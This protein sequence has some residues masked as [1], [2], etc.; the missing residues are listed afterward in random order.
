M[1]TPTL[2]NGQ[3]QFLRR[4]AHDLKPMTQVGKHGVTASVI[5]SCDEQLRAHELLKVKFLGHPEDQRD[6][7]EELA[8]ATRAILVSAIGGTI[9]LYRPN[10]EPER[11]RIVLP[12]P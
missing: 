4:L 6:M 1:N 5:A 12:R 3:R 8:A 7:A 11:Q 9:V 10:P 2:S